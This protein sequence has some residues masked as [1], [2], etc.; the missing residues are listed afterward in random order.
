MVLT[1]LHFTHPIHLIIGLTLWSL[2]FVAVYSGLSVACAVVPPPPEAGALTGLNAVL[3]GVSFITAVGLA[4]L[5]WGSCQVAKQHQGRQRFH[6][7]VSA[8]LD[9][10]SAF[11]VVF[12][13]M[14]IISVPPCL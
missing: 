11:G 2:W 7:T 4:A 12:A 8:W 9:L 14:P 3:G 5:A 1:R 10:F 6:A 13:G